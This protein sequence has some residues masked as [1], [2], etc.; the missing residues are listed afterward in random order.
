[1]V[2]RHI[3][4]AHAPLPCMIE[5]THAGYTGVQRYAIATRATTS[6]KIETRQRNPSWVDPYDGKGAAVT[7][8]CCPSLHLG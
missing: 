5:V 8:Q 1:M 2:Y 7:L 6:L 3:A 4:V